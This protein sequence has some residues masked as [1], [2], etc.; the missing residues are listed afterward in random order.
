MRVIFHLRDLL[1]QVKAGQLREACYYVLSFAPFEQSSHEA[2]LLALFLQDLGAILDFG[3]GHTMAPGILCDW[4][5]SL[6]N[7]RVLAKYPCFATLVAD[8]LFLRSDRVRYHPSECHIHV[9]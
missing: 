8:V 5:I 6:Y 4:F 9:M 1:K 2:T 3:D 7:H